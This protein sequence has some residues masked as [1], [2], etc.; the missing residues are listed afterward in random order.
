MT[1]RSRVCLNVACLMGALFN[2]S[3]S[4]DA[5][6]D[7]AVINANIITI[8]ADQPRAEAFAVDGDQITFVG[9]NNDVQKLIDENTRVIDAN[10]KTITP[11]FNDA[12]IHPS[13][14]YPRQSPLASVDC[15]PAATPTIDALIAALRSKA[16]LVQKGLWVRGSRYQETKLGRHPT[17]YD[18]DK[19]SGN[20]PIRIGHSSGHL[21][22]FNSYA[23]ELAGIT[24]ETPDPEGGRFDR[25]ENGVPNGICR[26]SAASIVRKAG[27][28][29][30]RASTQEQVDGFLKRF[31]EYVSHGITSVQDAGGN[32]MSKFRLYEKARAAG[33]PVR[34][35]MMMS[36]FGIDDL[37]KLREQKGLGD[38]Y[39][40]LGGIKRFHGNSLSGQTCWLYEPYHGRSDYFGIPPKRSQD[41]LDRRILQIHNAGL[42]ACVHSNGDREIDMV[43][44]AIERAVKAS[45]RVDHRHRIEHASVVNE[46]ILERVKNLGVVLAPH[47]YVYEHGDKMEAFGE[48][49]WN[50]MHPNGSAI[51]MGIPVAGT[52]DSPVSAADPLLRIQSMVTRQSAEGKVYGSKQRV[53]AEQAIRIWTLGSAYASFDED[54]KGSITPGKLAD[55]TMLSADPTAVP[56]N[57]I[58]DVKV[59]MTVIGG[60]LVYDSTP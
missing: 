54:I 41:Y 30:P 13:P 51:A 5:G 21:S 1:D 20:H 53:T 49:R 6:C 48:K 57:K 27:P 25:D 7:V 38:D 15:R 4:T 32:S 12:H 19:A 22:V 47:S 36:R 24:R 43:L 37:V 50:M 56:A 40:K 26:E 9:S 60:R 58:K 18:L 39:L 45:S 35:Y 44:T 28:A 11:G 23:L 46:R 3:E 55:F 2:L 8:D 31:E 59:M 52:S 16:E 29:S 17:R 42:Q 34:V 14:I 33:Q 10:G